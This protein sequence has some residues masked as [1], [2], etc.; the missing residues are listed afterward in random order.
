MLALFKTNLLR[1][2]MLADGGLSLVAGALLAFLPAT[3]ADLLGSALSSAAVLAIG[4]F[5]IGW[6]IFHLLAA[7]SQRPNMGSVRIAVAGD[8][9][10]IAASIAL[11]VSDWAAF[12][13]IGVAAIAVVAVAVA[14]IMLLKIIGLNASARAAVA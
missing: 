10:W 8:A 7:K 11:L 4:I 6:G 1:H 9:L 2:V 14:D 5:L 3:I 13:A 12:S